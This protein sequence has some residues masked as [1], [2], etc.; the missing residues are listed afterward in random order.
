MAQ[1]KVTSDQKEEKETTQSTEST[2]SVVYT[3]GTGR[4]GELG[5]D[6]V[7]KSQNSLLPSPVTYFVKQKIS[8]EVIACGEGY[9]CAITSKK[10]LRCAL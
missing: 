5:H 4:S 2:L 3:W 9:S 7:D 6:H 10:Q 1:P 8:I